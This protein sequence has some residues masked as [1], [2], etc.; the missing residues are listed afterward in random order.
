MADDD[1][2]AALRR[3]LLFEPCDRPQVEVV[4]RPVQQHHVRA[5]RQHADQ[6]RSSRLAARQPRGGL[7]ARQPEM[8]QKHARLADRRRAPGPPRRRTAPWHGRRGRVPA[9]GPAASCPAAHSARRR[10]AADLRRRAE[11]GWT[12]RCRCARRAPAAPRV[13]PTA[14]RRPA[15]AC[16]R[17]AGRLHREAAG[18]APCGAEVV[19]R[20]PR[21]A[22]A[23]GCAPWGGRSSFVRENA[24]RRRGETR[25]PLPTERRGPP[26]A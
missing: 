8:L 7:V 26:R 16:R 3:D 23:A 17:C 5:R 1:E 19:P 14:T 20:R 9:A 24:R 18:A 13:R 4:G 10:P 22:V 11:A 2:R 25:V 12:C 6:R 21:Q 15:A